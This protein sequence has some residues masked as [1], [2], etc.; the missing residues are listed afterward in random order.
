MKKIVIEEQKKLSIKANMLWNSMGSLIY[1]GV[2]WLLTVLVVRL[3]NGYDAAGLLAL[4]M[5]VGNIFIPFANYRMRIYQVSDVV[6]EYS[7]SEYM[8]FRCVTVLLSFLACMVYAAVTCNFE[9]LGIVALWL[10]Y[11]GL[12][13]IIYVMHGLD[14]QN[15]RMDI[16]GKSFIMRGVAVF[17]VFCVGMYF[18][19]SLFLS[20]LFMIAVTLLIGFLWDYRRSRFFDKLIPEINR[21][22][23]AVLLKRCFLITVA[24]IACSATLT[25]PRQYLSVSCG[26]WALGIYASVAAP[27][28]IIQMGGS[29]IYGPLLGS[30]ASF[31]EKKNGKKFFVLLL[32]TTLGMATAGIICG[33]LLE[34]FGSALLGFLFGE[35]IVEYSFL[36]LPLVVLAVLTAYLW[37]INDLL[38]TI[39]DLKGGF[40]ANIVASIIAFVVCWGFVDY[41]GMNGVSFTGI[42]AYAIGIVLGILFV[43]H[44]LMKR[45]TYGLSSKNE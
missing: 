33:I 23:V 32:K 41:F 12:G 21:R 45:F 2:Q 17:L 16:I 15:M 34:F 43:C 18:T 35:A 4:A 25:I 11:K 29:Y 36:I 28:A 6:H 13:A 22:L 20:L 7:T 38:I 31:Y 1:L 37:F 8:G 27:I 10:I 26:D 39:R 40:V 24:N 44:K 14:Q 19:A 5:A 9:A 3:S 42:V 30:F